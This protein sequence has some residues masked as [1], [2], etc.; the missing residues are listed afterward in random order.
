M[1]KTIVFCADI[2]HANRMK[3]AL[4]NL[5]AYRVAE[6][7]RYIMQITGDNAEGKAQLSYFID[8]TSPYPVIVTTSELMTT[9]VDA[10]TCK[11]IVLDQRIE[12]MTK[13]KQVIGRG[14]RIDEEYGKRWFT[15]IDFK[16]ATQN[17]ADKDFDGAPVKIYV[18][19][20][21]GD[22]TVDPDETDGTDPIPDDSIIVDPPPPQPRQ[23][24]Y[25][26]G[27]RVEPVLER[28]QYYGKDGLVTE[29]I[30]DYTRKTVERHYHNLDEFLK[31]W[32]T[33]EHKQ[34]V[35][36]QLQAHGVVWD[37]LEGAGRCWQRC[38]TNTSSK[39]WKALKPS[40]PSRLTPSASSVPRARSCKPSADV[41][42]TTKHCKRWSR[43]YI[44]P[45]SA[46]IPASSDRTQGTVTCPA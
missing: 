31:Q 1:D 24:Y 35:I 8:S 26:E 42:T 16:G 3:L 18:P 4:E 28:T 39:A 7:E 11:L 5:N 2:D 36:Q 6:D 22:G 34:E 38:W 20:D 10:K 29:S 40:T 43:N 37:E 21:E 41:P 15:I 9:G 17:F 45:E 25:I 19:K 32:N 44:W 14:T 12:S 30:R 27:S 23:K 46:I 33:A 13:F